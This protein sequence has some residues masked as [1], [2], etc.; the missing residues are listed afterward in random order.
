M[1]EKPIV[2]ILMGDATGIGTEILAKLAVRHFF[3]DYFRPILI[4]DARVFQMGLDLIGGK[5]DYQAV[6]S[7]DDIDWE[8]GLPILDQKDL[9]PATIEIG[10]LSAECGKACNNMIK[11]AVDLF[12]QGKIKGI[13]FAP[14]N[15][16]ALIMG[17]LQAHSEIE[18]F[19]SLLGQE[20][21]FGE[22]NYVDDVWTT[23]VTSHIPLKAVSDHLTVPKI[24]DTIQLAY[25]TV[26]QAGVKNPRIGISALNPH[27]GENGMCGDEEITVIKPAMEEAKKLGIETS[28]PYSSDILFIKA[29]DG[30][31]DAAVTMFHDQGQIAMKL[32]GFDR[33]VTIEAGFAVPI[34][35]CAHGTAHD[36]AGKG[37]A[38][39]TAFE[40]AMKVL[41]R[42]AREVK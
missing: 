29:F 36:I 27:A 10:K 22:V 41:A 4:G 37:I 38:N 33:G 8:K 16:T 26:K 18:E 14:L 21:G 17:G 12:K 20:R 25:Q 31:L 2:A 15:K 6:D 24:V 3:D 9:D 1:N 23:R 7:V 30:D 19:A 32:K 34:C 5:A 11:V 40:N 42:M 28:G 13:G 39:T 35:T